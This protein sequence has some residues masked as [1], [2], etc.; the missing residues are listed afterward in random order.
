MPFAELRVRNG[1]PRPGIGGQE[2]AMRGQG[3]VVWML[4]GVL[5]G[6][7][8]AGCGGPQQQPQQPRKQQVQSDS[9]RFFEKMRQEEHERSAGP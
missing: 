1:R 4:A 6:L 5:L 3:W 9:D 8:L 2:E 7:C